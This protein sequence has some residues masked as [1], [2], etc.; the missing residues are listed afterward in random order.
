MPPAVRDYLVKQGFTQIEIDAIVPAMQKHGISRL[1]IRSFGEKR[2]A[3]QFGVNQGL[4]QKPYGI[5]TKTGFDATVTKNGVTY[6]S[7]ADIL[8][9]EIKGRPATVA[10]IQKFTRTANRNY[11]KLW[12]ERGL[13]V[14]GIPANPPFQHGAH[15]SMAQV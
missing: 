1:S 12:N 11:T 3:R 9:V 4:P 13:G 14:R 5:K 2:F 10:E 8:H 15:T 6:V 7:D